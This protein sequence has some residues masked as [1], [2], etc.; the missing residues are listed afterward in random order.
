MFILFVKKMLDDIKTERIF[1]GS[2][3]RVLLFGSVLGLLGGIFFALLYFFISFIPGANPV[4]RVSE[5]IVFSLPIGML[6]TIA[7][8]IAM[9]S[10][11]AFI[12]W[13]GDK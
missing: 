4:F 2:I 7:I 9:G 6:I 3:L 5:S 1:K 12:V 11:F 8:G 10:L 13:L